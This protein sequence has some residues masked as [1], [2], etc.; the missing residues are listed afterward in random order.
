MAKNVDGKKMTLEEYEK[1]YSKPEN[2]K[3]AK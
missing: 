3:A 2:I 1:K